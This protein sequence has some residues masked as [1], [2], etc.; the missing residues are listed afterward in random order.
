MLP[1]EDER[2]HPRRARP[3]GGDVVPNSELRCPKGVP[4][5]QNEGHAAW[6]GALEVSP[7]QC[8]A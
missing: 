6:R 3:W 4:I 8:A 2:S 5:A 7:G 1:R